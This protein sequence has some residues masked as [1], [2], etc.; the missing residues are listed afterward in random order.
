[1]SPFATSAP[2]GGVL[3]L[4][5][6]SL[7]S[8]PDSK[9]TNQNNTMR[10]G[11]QHQSSIS[12]L[13]SMGADQS[14]KHQMLSREEWFH[15]PISRKDAEQLLIDDGDFLVRESQGSPGQYVLTGMQSNSK[16]HLLLVDPEG[17]VRT[18]DRTFDS[19]SHL[20][21]YHRD[22]ALPIISAESA[23]RLKK[24]VLSSQQATLPK[25]VVG[26]LHFR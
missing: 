10:I 1:M 17:I 23:L 20:I 18:K 19:V 8:K 24:P 12:I 2:G 5:T 16:K 9:T 13:P 11:D 22:N 26:N 4:V 6:S 7:S 14:M 21:C 15:G 25:A 3:G